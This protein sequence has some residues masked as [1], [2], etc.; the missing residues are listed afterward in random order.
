MAAFQAL[1]CNANHDSNSMVYGIAALPT[2]DST[3]LFYIGRV[4]TGQVGDSEVP[5]HI[6]YHERS[7]YRIS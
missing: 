1:K 7:P 4:S 5:L 2:K 6:S 3:F